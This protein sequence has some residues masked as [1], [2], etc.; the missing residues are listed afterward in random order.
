MEHPGWLLSA[1]SETLGRTAT[2]P[3]TVLSCVINSMYGP[4]AGAETV[5]ELGNKKM[6]H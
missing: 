5:R 1:G 4:I 2:T 3:A 6:S